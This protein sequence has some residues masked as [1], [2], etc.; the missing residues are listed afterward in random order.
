MTLK[1]Q[2]EQE[3][4]NIASFSKLAKRVFKTGNVKQDI[5]NYTNKMTSSITIKKSKKKPLR[6]DT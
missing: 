4:K 5:K 2:I 6:G 1:E 3:E